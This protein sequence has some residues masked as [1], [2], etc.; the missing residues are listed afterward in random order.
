[1]LSEVPTCPGPDTPS[2]GGVGRITTAINITIAI[3]RFRCGVFSKVYG[4]GF[5]ATC[6][7]RSLSFLG[8]PKMP[9][10]LYSEDL[11]KE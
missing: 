9:S 7:F 1:M 2:N 10:R 6:M 5:K 11:Q 4:S 3:I 8:P